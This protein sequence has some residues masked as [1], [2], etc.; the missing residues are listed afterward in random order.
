M[1]LP[2]PC[3]PL[4]ELLAEKY[5]ALRV[6]RDQLR[7]DLAEVLANVRA[8][9]DAAGDGGLGVIVL[10]VDLMRAAAIN[11]G[12]TCEACDGAGSAGDHDCEQCS[13]WG[14]EVTT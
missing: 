10:D 7:S 14:W 5:E 3:A 13:G 12:W 1:S 11:A 6:E 8:F 2:H 9:I 4:C